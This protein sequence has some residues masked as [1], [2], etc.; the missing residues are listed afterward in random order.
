MSNEEPE[1]DVAKFVKFLKSAQ[2]DTS[3]IGEYSQ[4]VKTT[5][6]LSFKDYL[7]AL[8]LAYASLDEKQRKDLIRGV[9]VIVMS[10]N[11]KRRVRRALRAVGVDKS[12]AR[13][14]SLGAIW[15]AWSLA[16]NAA[17][18]VQHARYLADD[19]LYQ[20]TSDPESIE[21]S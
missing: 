10:L 1:F 7:E 12:T 9:V 15:G 11:A 4:P 14:L 16:A 5:S 2:D 18:G 20:K 21:S 17:T 19:G 3:S 6:S 8:G 13:A